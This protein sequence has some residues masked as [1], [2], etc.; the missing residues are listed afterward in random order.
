MDTGQKVQNPLG[1]AGEWFS[2]AFL[3]PL[4]CRLSSMH[5]ACIL[6]DG[7]GK[8]DGV[9]TMPGCW[10]SLVPTDA[11]SPPQHPKLQCPMLTSCFL[12]PQPAPL[13]VMVT[14]MW[15]RSWRSVWMR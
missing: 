5:A 8:W 2:K 11:I 3:E 10:G 14:R 15:T 4:T 13:A 9:L 6:G 12:L 7:A 1:Q